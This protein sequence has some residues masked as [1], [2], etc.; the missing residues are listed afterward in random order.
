V[1]DDKSA[2]WSL[3][4]LL[5]VKSSSGAAGGSVSLPRCAR[6]GEISG[7]AR[8]PAEKKTLGCITS[9][10]LTA[11]PL[12]NARAGLEPVLET[13]RAPSRPSGLFLCPV[14]RHRAGKRRHRC[15]VRPGLQPVI[16][17]LLAA[18]SQPE[19]GGGEGRLPLAGGARRAATSPPTRGRAPRV[20]LP[21]RSG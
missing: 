13:Q 1:G 17:P 21:P 9:E 18:S 14:W 16:H 6:G 20:A 19:K 4:I 8:S 11:V 12:G 2:P 3:V 15:W 7:S 10:G 5:H